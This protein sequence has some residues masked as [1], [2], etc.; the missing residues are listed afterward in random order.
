MTS[1]FFIPLPTI[2]LLAIGVAITIISGFYLRLDATL[3]PALAALVIVLV[4]EKSTRDWSIALERI[5]CV[6]LGCFIALLITFVFSKG[7]FKL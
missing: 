5:I 7:G 2:I 1:I 6:C 4:Q 3:R